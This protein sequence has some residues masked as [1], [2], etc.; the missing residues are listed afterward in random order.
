[1]G[2]LVCKKTEDI[3]TSSVTSYLSTNI[4]VSVPTWLIMLEVEG[5]GEKAPL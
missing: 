5:I 4:L 1:L 2:I 3:Q